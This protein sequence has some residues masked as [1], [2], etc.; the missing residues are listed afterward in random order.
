MAVWNLPPDLSGPSIPV[1]DFWA[2]WNGAGFRSPRMK[3]RQ[4]WRFR[5]TAVGTR[6]SCTASELYSQL[7]RR[8]RKLFHSR[9]DLLIHARARRDA[10]CSSFRSG[11]L[12][13]K[14]NATNMTFDS[15]SAYVVSRETDWLNGCV[16]PAHD[17]FRSAFVS[18]NVH[19][20]IHADNTRF[21]SVH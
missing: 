7:C 19:F 11:C 9:R 21:I 14:I 12:Y 20:S 13:E 10:F 5:C 2:V 16:S 8:P 15:D 6:T 17:L 1:F 4:F 18:V 3:R